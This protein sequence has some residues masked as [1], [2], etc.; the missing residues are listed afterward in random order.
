M[1]IVIDEYGA[2]AGLVTMEDIVEEIVGEI[3]DEYDLPDD[4]VTW[5][6]DRTLEVTG[7]LSID[8]FNEITGVH[9]HQEAVRT[10]AGL[11]FARLGRRPTLNDEIEIRRRAAAPALRNISGARITR[12]TVKLPTARRPARPVPGA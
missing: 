2:T 9:L 7:S 12:L 6:D 8:D 3:Q 4:T 10:M 1:A 5:I 11:V